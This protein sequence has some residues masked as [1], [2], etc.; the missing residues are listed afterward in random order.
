MNDY[1]Q[2]SSVTIMPENLA[3]HVGIVLEE[4]VY[5]NHTGYAKQ[6]D[7]SRLPTNSSEILPWL[8]VSQFL[9]NSFICSLIVKTQHVWLLVAYC[10]L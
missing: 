10:L 4:I 1:Y 8:A 5:D 9:T 6:A 3:Q 2:Y 7:S